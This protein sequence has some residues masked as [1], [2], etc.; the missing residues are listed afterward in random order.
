MAEVLAVTGQKELLEAAPLLRRTL[1]V[2]DDYL[3]P[4][5]A[6]QVSLLGR[7]RAQHEEADPG[8]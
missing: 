3:L 7:T 6:L 4:L 8:Q 5:H 2:R 1:A